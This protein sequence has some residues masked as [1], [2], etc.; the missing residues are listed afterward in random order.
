MPGFGD[1][2]V[3]LVDLPLVGQRRGAISVAA[4]TK[5]S[6][7]RSVMSQAGVAGDGARP[8][9]T[10]EGMVPQPVGLQARLEQVLHR[11][12]R[13]L[14]EPGPVRRLAAVRAIRSAVLARV[15]T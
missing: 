6:M 8:V 5:T 11:G 7:A 10:F 14:D 9:Q 1:L 2:D 12:V 4:A 3:G 13:D 15:A